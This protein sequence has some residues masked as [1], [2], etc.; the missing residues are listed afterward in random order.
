MTSFETTEHIQKKRNKAKKRKVG[1]LM[2][3]THAKYRF[4]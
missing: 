1:K 3:N 2:S 4:E